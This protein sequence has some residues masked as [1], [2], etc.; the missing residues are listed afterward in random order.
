MTS[1][2]FKFYNKL[3]FNRQYII[4][5]NHRPCDLVTSLCNSGS[6]IY[7]LIKKLLFLHIKM[8]ENGN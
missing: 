1:D 5:Y 3:Y 6:C 2:N 4:E 8:I 7:Y